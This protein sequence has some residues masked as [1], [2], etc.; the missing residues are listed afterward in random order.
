MYLLSRF[1][2]SDSRLQFVWYHIKYVPGDVR[3][4]EGLF[5]D[6]DFM[7]VECATRPKMA[8][9]DGIYR[10]SWRENKSQDK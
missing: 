5:Q 1:L 6:E 4:A 8:T 3:Y 7:Q 2:F 10:K 9:G